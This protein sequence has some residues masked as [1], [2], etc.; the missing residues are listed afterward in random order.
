MAGG[1]LIKTKWS[2]GFNLAW[3]DEKNGSIADRTVVT[4]LYERL[5]SNQEVVSVPSRLV[6]G[7][8][9][10]GRLASPPLPDYSVESP[11]VDE[12]DHYLDALLREQLLLARSVCFDTPFALLLQRRLTILQR[13]FY[14]VTTRYVSV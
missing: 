13:I 7:H 14:A 12:Q 1:F 8:L 5:L 10:G 2:D 3:A 9:N 6:A 4:A 11:S